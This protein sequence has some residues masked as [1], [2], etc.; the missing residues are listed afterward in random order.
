[1]VDVKQLLIDTLAPFGYPIYLQ[2]SLGADEAYPATFFTF[3]NNETN[4]AAFYDNGE[5]ETIWV[6]DL[7]VYSSDPSVVNSV[8]RE[9]K[10]MLKAVGFIVD[11]LGYDLVSDEPTHTGRGIEL[12]YIERIGD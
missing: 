11:G 1:M 10:G 5:T 12:Y 9:A 2:G 7:N 4:D 3:W 8:L 6:F